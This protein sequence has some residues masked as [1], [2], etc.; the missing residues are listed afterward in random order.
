VA[1][2]QVLAAAPDDAKPSAPGL[3]KDL[4]AALEKAACR[5]RTHLR[6]RAGLINDCGPK[7]MEGD[8]E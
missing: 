8:P 7:S 1:L 3:P 4:V 2:T 6:G 5:A